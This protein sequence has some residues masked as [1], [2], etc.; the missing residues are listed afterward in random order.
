MFQIDLQRHTMRSHAFPVLVHTLRS[1]AFPE[2]VHTMISHAFPVLVHT[3]ISHAFSVL[4]Q[5][6]RSHDF[7]VLVH[8][9]RSHAFPV[10]V[11]FRLFESESFQLVYAH[12]HKISKSCDCIEHYMFCLISQLI[13][14]S[15]YVTIIVLLCC[16]Y[17]RHAQH[18]N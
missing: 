13:I 18:F 15:K 8:T 6:M 10:L 5:I 11:A 7:L 17:N 2:L 16:I 3:M 1:H 12:K 9:M 4:V 14:T